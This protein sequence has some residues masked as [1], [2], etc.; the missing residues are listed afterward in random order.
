MKKQIMKVVALVLLMAFSLSIGAIAAEKE[1]AEP[2][3]NSY[4]KSFAAS[5]TASNGAV[6]VNFITKGTGVMT[7]IGASTIKIYAVGG[8]TP[9]KTFYSSSTPSMLGSN[10]ISYSSSVTYYGN[11]GTSYYAVV[12]HYAANSSGSGTQTYTTGTT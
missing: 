1:T 3:S 8:S 4:I 9:V 6:T 2:C 11:S 12:T 7:S 5:I 10:R